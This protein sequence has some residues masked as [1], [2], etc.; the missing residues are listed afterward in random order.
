MAFAH[1]HMLAVLK[2]SKDLKHAVDTREQAESEKYC[3]GRDNNC[4]GVRLR[5]SA[6]FPSLRRTI[7]LSP[8]ERHPGEASGFES[9]RLSIGPVPRLI[10]IGPSEEGRI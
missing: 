10:Q 7:W 1:T 5:C 8:A 6:R 3:A 9:E 2:K 4:G